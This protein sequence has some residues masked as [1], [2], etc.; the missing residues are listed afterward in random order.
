MTEQQQIESAMAM[1]EAQR[2]LLGDTVVE[3]AL[4]PLRA[5]LASCKEAAGAPEG[6]AEEEETL[7]RQKLKTVSILFLDMVGSTVLSQRLEPE[8][9]HDAIDGALRKFTEVVRQHR[10]KVLQYAGDSLLAVFGADTSR[11]DDAEFAVRCGLALLHEGRIQADRIL[12]RYHFEGFNVRLGL[13]TGGV[14]LGGGV[15]AD[16]SIRGIGVNIAARM[17]QTAPSGGLRI[18]QETF[19]HVRGLFDVLVQEPIAVKGLDEPV[20]TYLVQGVRKREFF[21]PT[22]GIEGVQTPLVGREGPLKQ[23]QQCFAGLQLLACRSGQGAPGDARLACITLVADAGVGK[24]RLT[25]EFLQWMQ[26]LE[27]PCR[28]FTAR[29]VPS[30]QQRPF[31]LLCELLCAWLGIEDSDS[32]DTARQQISRQVAALFAADETPERAEAHA[33]VLGQLIG[34]DFSGSPHVK[35]ILEDGKQ[36]RDRAFNTVAQMLRRLDSPSV[37]GDLKRPV[38][39][40]VLDD[41]HWADD[42]SLDFVQA[43]CKA[44]RDLPMLVLG[45]TRPDL[46]ERRNDW[47][48]NT[49]ELHTRIDLRPLDNAFSQTLAHA[50]LQHVRN[51]PPTLLQLLMQRTQGNPFYMEELVKMLVEEGAIVRLDLNTEEADTASG[52]WIVLPEKLAGTHVPVTLAGVIQARLDRLS[53]RDKLSLQEASII[54][55]QF[56]HAILEALDPKS[57]DSLAALTQRDLVAPQTGGPAQPDPG[58]E[59]KKAMGYA[60]K[61]QI[62]HRV[63][64]DTV[65]MRVKRLYH[66][67]AA[68]WMVSRLG[69]A[70][71]DLGAIG[72]HY[73][74]AGDARSAAE[75]FTR[76]VE[77]ALASFSHSLVEAHADKVLTLSPHDHELRWR[78]LLARQRSFRLRG[79]T[80]RAEGDLHSLS[81][82]ADGLND[83]RKRATVAARRAMLLFESAKNSEALAVASAAI[84]IAK[85]VGDVTH[86]L[87]AMQAGAGALITL[88]RLSEAYDIS[89]EGYT[90]ATAHEDLQHQ[91]EFL[92]N[93]AVI[94]NARGQSVEAQEFLRQSVSLSKS[95]GNM[96]LMI[97]SSINLGDSAFR[98][99]QYAT[100]NHE[101]RS[102][103][104]MA[105][106]TGMRRFELVSLVNL[107]GVCHFSGNSMEAIAY[108]RKSL[109]IADQIGDTFYRNYALYYLG[110]A[111][112][113]VHLHADALQ[114]LE[115]AKD[116]FSSLSIQSMLTE[117]T[118]AIASAHLSTGSASEA[119][120]HIERVLGHIANAGGFDGAEHPFSTRLI[121]YRVLS[122]CADVRAKDIILAA[123]KDLR[124]TLSNIHDGEIMKSFTAIPYISEIILSAGGLGA[125]AGNLAGN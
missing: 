60:F 122:A 124:D 31:G 117:V 13:H 68:E 82:I 47:G 40:L 8:E 37:H 38:N 19:H 89:T 75:Y 61:H 64:Y 50:L 70:G 92:N 98:L 119:K 80:G 4:A 57:V 96:S 106:S 18:S 74:Q 36:I 45:L 2:P 22:R 111:Q 49:P 25:M 94:K 62:L 116:G 20:Q 72:H 93:L 77:N 114:S 5:R 43:L 32:T 109:G 58:D 78:V 1:L 123:A 97:S 39:V 84:D 67:Q 65:L 99:G 3:T 6:D 120:T 28:L 48:K 100:A 33:H 14:V 17:E 71:D 46:Y 29:A 59:L 95:I 34:F 42:G 9:I 108:G 53:A 113:A 104:D 105:C 115:R 12:K 88:G 79:E 87:V 125:R 41:L 27:A 10:G 103:H 86:Q 110:L 7:V 101:F 35:G 85:S 118:A 90:L 44:N 21:N 54:G 11:E 30:T 83:G 112:S 107:A 15:D 81:L 51:V 91:A 63:T 24:S 76:S 52:G 66:Q 102:A 56:W 121:C 69:R 55:I 23:L 73:E 16:G 26:T